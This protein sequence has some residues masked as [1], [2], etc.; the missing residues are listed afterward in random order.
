MASVK[1][2]LTFDDVLLT[3]QKSSVLPKDV[4][5][6]TNL[7]K[8]I[9]LNMP[10]LSAAMDTVTESKMAIAMAQNGGLG[11]IHKNF[12][13]ETQCSEVKKVKRFEAGIVYD[14]ITM[15]P[16]NTIE[17][18][19]SVM[20]EHS[21][22]G[23]PVV[24]QNNILQGIITN[25][26]VRFIVNTKTKV[27]DLMTKK[28]ITMTKTQSSTM[29][30]FGL[31]KKLLQENRIEKLVV[32]DNNYKCIGLITVK[33]IQ[34]GEK[35]PHSVRDKNGQLL[36]GA[37]IGTK[38]IDF[39]R[40]LDLDKVGVD[41]LFIDTA[42]GHSSLVLEAFKQIR[43]KIQTPIVVG[44]IATP[45]AAKDLIKLGADAIKVGIGPGSI[46]T[47]RVVAGVGVPQFT[48]LL[49]IAKVTNKAKI[50]MISDG[51][52]RYSGDIIKALAAGANCIMA[53]SLF[54]GTD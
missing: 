44:N 22:S 3:P 18:V 47:T 54:A 27:K 26:D 28:V 35:F 9:K 13:I 32:V 7:T 23:F 33:D 37:A 41:V 34:R 4:D 49:D 20:K 51:G 6:S 30:S 1:E 45:E 14:P 46:C 53:G 52:I 10:I 42:H 5:I 38:E 12:N 11:V 2:Y 17:D 29:S 21:I 19:M 39:R 40:A 31:A 8:E 15:Q 50:P 48:A 24:D 36:V 16:D 43:K 25:R